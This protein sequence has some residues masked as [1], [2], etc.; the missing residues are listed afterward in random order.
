MTYL[1]IL[2]SSHTKILSGPAS[3]S[4]EVS[5]IH[6][7]TQVSDETKEIQYY[8]LLKKNCNLR[9]RWMEKIMK[10]ISKRRELTG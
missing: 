9:R 7:S 3:D 4:P 8:Q 1:I 10:E 6:E 5:G 2:I